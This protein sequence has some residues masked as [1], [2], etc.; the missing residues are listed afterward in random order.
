MNIFAFLLCKNKQITCLDG[1]PS[2]LKYV[3][4]AHWY[5]NRIFKSKEK[6]VEFTSHNWYGRIPNRYDYELKVKVNQYNDFCFISPRLIKDFIL[7]FGNSTGFNIL[8]KQIR[9]KMIRQHIESYIMSASFPLPFDLSGIGHMY[10]Y[11]H[12]KELLRG[13]VVC[14]NSQWLHYLTIEYVSSDAS[15]QIRVHANLNL[16][17]FKLQIDSDFM[18]IPGSISFDSFYHN[19]ES[20]SKLYQFFKS[21]GKFVTIKILDEG[22]LGSDP[23]A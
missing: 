3:V 8:K 19:V 11:Y 6:F 21:L 20:K 14:D 12:I 22:L 7:H 16:E 4:L 9:S 17:L 15:L 5:E 1:L 18:E 23:M 2:E 13:L 10:M